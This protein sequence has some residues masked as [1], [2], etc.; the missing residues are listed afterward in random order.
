MRNVPLLSAQGLTHCLCSR[1]ESEWI[2]GSHI[3]CTHRHQISP[4]I[5]AHNKCAI[6]YCP[7]AHAAVRAPAGNEAAAR[8]Q[9]EPAHAT[10]AMRSDARGA[11]LSLPTIN[12][13]CRCACQE[14]RGR[15]C[16]CPSVL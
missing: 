5:S 3:E 11:A 12:F 13:A 16:D 15:P 9:R 2:G 14:R 8:T 7:H 6:G 4:T 10:M 1:C